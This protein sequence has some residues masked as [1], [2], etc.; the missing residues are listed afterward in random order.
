MRKYK[1][2]KLCYWGPTPG[3]ETIYHPGDVVM[4]HGNEPC[5]EEFFEA[6]D[7]PAAEPAPEVK[8]R[9]RKPAE[10]IG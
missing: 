1:C 2:K 3:T 6:I 9:G 5:L 4:A 7:A 8:R 10:D